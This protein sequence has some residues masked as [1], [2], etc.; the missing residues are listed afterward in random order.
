MT[1]ASS[2]WLTVVTIV[3][4]DDAG[5]A[6]TSESLSCQDLAGVE[7]VVVD[8][9]TDT[10]SIPAALERPGQPGARYSR[11]PPRGIYA[12]MN[13]GLQQANGEYVLF[14]NAGDRLHSPA[15]LGAIRAATDSSPEWLYGAASFIDVEGHVVTPPPFDYEDEQAHRFSRGRF[16]THQ[17]T[18][19]RTDV[20]R[21][22]GGFDP[23]FSITADYAAFLRLTLRSQPRELA[24]VIA[25]FS[26]GGASEQAWIESLR[27]FHRARVQVL[28]LTGRAKAADAL[29]TVWL[30]CRMGAARVLRRA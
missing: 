8:G 5:F 21:A 10:T 17:A 22:V 4:D 19:V 2:P 24:T 27:Q 16:P 13:E 11:Q 26:V 20:L 12:A 3:K 15:V 9:S 25:D 23:A 29:A 30:G 7:W 14:L 18:V 28:G 6:T 1:D